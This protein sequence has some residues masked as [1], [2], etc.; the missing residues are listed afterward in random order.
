MATTFNA[1]VGNVDENGAVV[2]ARR[3]KLLYSVA[4]LGPNDAIDSGELD[5][6]GIQEVV[7]VIKNGNTTQVRSPVI[8]LRPVT[9]VTASAITPVNIAAG[10]T[11]T[12]A[13]GTG[14]ASTGITAA[15]AVCA[16]PLLQVT[17]AAPVGGAGNGHVYIWG[18]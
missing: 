3:A 6:A 4:T 5:L 18:R 12:Y 13:L 8:N 2:G 9:G 17:S 14:A 1:G 11:V 7:I 15:Y 16:P 10:A